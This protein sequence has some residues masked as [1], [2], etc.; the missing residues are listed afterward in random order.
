MSCYEDEIW[1]D[2]TEYSDFFQISNHGRVYSKRS[3]KILV[4]GITKQGYNT[5]SSK[6]GGRAGKYICLKVHRMVAK[7][8]I[9]NSYN[10]P[11][12]NHIDGNK[13]N[14]NV[15]NLEWCTSSENTQHAYDTGLKKS[16]KGEDNPTAKLTWEIVDFIRN[17]YK[18]NDKE[19]GARPLSRKY[20]VDR[21]LIKRI[22][23]NK[24]WIK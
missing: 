4:Q 3:N 21:S 22:I 5:I 2:D 17:N 12:V 14:N 7:A 1:K 8:F 20:G 18:S 19:Y 9:P 16:M 11:E 23:D 15:S 24:T 13:Q 10:K 6:I